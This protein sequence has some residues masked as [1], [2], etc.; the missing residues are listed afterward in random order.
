MQMPFFDS[1]I[2]GSFPDIAENNIKNLNARRDRQASAFIT[3]RASQSYNIDFVVA[4]S[5]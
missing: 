3:L 5:Q 1:A 4:H 2:S